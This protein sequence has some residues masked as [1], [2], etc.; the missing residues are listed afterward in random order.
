MKNSK[1]VVF[2]RQ[3]ALL[4]ELREAKTIDVETVAKKLNVSPTT[5][6]RD[7]IMFEK[8]NLIE[9]FHGGATLLEE[10][11]RE[12]D[13]PTDSHETEDKEQKQIIARYA[14]ELVEEGDTIFINSSSTALLMLDYLKGKRV[15][16]VTNN[17]F[18]VN[19]PHDSQVEIIMTGGEIYQRRKS[20][21]GEFALHTLT[22]IIADKAFIGVGGISADGGITT[23]VLPETA[24][25]ETMLRRCQGKRYV[26]AANSKIGREH[27]FHS[28]DV[29]Q[30]DCLITCQGSNKI[31][32]DAIKNS[33]VEVVELNI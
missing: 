18:A 26:L 13:V 22:K 4:K 19:Y 9:R 28:A 33:G 14:A 7:L 32:V 12:E 5:I 29:N 15:I 20:L 30:V 8:Q 1:S 16:V 11:L 21:V 10:S 25:N 24:I 31:E 2:K 27:N 3:Q 6:R 17:G 23:S